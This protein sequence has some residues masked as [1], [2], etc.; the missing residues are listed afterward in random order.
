MEKNRFKKLFNIE[1][2]IIF[3]VLSF[4]LIFI[5]CKGKESPLNTQLES[6][7]IIEELNRF[8]LINQDQ[9]S[10]LLGYSFI[11]FN[12]KG[13]LWSAEGGFANIEKEIKFNKSTVINVGELSQQFTI[14]GILKLYEENK[15]DI[16]KEVSFYLPEFFEDSS[17]RLKKIGNLKIST[18]IKSLTGYTSISPK[19]LKNY[20]FD[21]DLK[22]YLEKLNPIYAEDVKY[23]ES[24]LFIDLLGLV[25]QKISGKDFSSFIDEEIFKPFMMISST[26]SPE[27]KFKNVSLFYSIDPKIGEKIRLSSVIKAN[28][29]ILSP[30]TSMRSSSGDLAGFYSLFLNGDSENKFLSRD[31]INYCFM[32]V[33]PGQLDM[34]GFETGLG[35][36]LT[37]TDLGYAGKAPF[38]I[39]SFITHSVIVVLLPE[40]N[41]GIVCVANLSS[42]KYEDD[43]HQIAVNI[44]KKYIKLKF[45]IEPPSFVKPVEKK[46]PKNIG[47][48]IAGFYFSE[49]GIMMLDVRGNELQLS[50]NG[51]YSAFYYD[52]N[53]IFKPIEE[54]AYKEI[55]FIYPDKIALTF[56]TK[57]RIVMQKLIKENYDSSFLPV[58][59]IYKAQDIYT[60]PSSF[61]IKQYSNFYVIIADNAKE[62]LLVPIAKNEAK[63]LCDKTFILY[64]KKLYI[65]DSG[66]IMLDNAKYSIMKK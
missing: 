35:W 54:N 28:L 10:K 7:Q 22:S 4:F 66:E 57:A 39:G 58:T 29:N 47:E 12:D 9:S 40:K 30:S 53:N 50:Y 43:L 5:G 46:I 21:K 6:G 20:V 44:M 26:Y 15:I 59:G 3:C 63:I 60:Y 62:Y 45:N 24:P 37:N 27:K 41:I 48:K 23:T 25:I 42:P 32:P 51:G 16:E 33:Y 18:I 2:I 61:M 64:G 65:D 1:K 38:F 19:S 36:Q 31:T 14:S 49:K 55:E 13:E 56:N 34:E 11:L 17:D 52:K 8:M